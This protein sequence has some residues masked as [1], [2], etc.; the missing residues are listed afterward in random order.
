ML[1]ARQSLGGSTQR[2]ATYVEPEV[3]VSAANATPFLCFGDIVQLWCEQ[4]HTDLGLHVSARGGFMGADGF[5][6][7]QCDL[8]ITYN[9]GAASDVSDNLFRVTPKLQAQCQ[10]KLTEQLQKSVHISNNTKEEEFSIDFDELAI[11]DRL[12]HDT[13]VEAELNAAETERSLGHIVNYGQTVQLNHI[14]SGKVL[15]IRSKEV[16][17]VDNKCQRVCLSVTGGPEA[18]WMV[19]PRYRAMGV[20]EPVR[21]GHSLRISSSKVV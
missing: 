6:E 14:K 10:K 20:G 13:R 17:D 5:V 8:C 7:E 12:R 15:T 11:I 16:A 19:E 21:Y 18:W 9:R 3:V 4:V 2:S 1:S